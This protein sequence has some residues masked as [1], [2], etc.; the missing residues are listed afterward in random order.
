MKHFLLAGA[1]LV[2][3]CACTPRLHA[4]LGAYDLVTYHGKP[5]PFEGVRASEVNLT[6]DGTLL[7]YTSRAVTLGLPETVT[8][9]MFGSFTIGAWSGECTIVMLRFSDP[10]G[11]GEIMS[12]VCADELTIFESEAVYK[13]R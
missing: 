10:P 5:L 11:E 9:T 4:V 1:L 13:R 7:V 2:T 8:D 6:P 12:E 3:V